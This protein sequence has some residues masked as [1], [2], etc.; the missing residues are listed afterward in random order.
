MT[1][2]SSETYRYYKFAPGVGGGGSNF[3]IGRKKCWPDAYHNNW[4]PEKDRKYTLLPATFVIEKSVRVLF[5]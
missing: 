5:T 3:K 1:I 2:T 4:G